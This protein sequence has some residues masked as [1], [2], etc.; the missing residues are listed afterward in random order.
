MT[1]SHRLQRL[2]QSRRC[3]NYDGLHSVLGALYACSLAT[4]WKVSTK[5]CILGPSFSVISLCSANFPLLTL[6]L[7]TRICHLPGHVM[8][9]T[10]KVVFGDSHGTSYLF[11][12]VLYQ[13]LGSLLVLRLNPRVRSITGFNQT[14]CADEHHSRT[15]NLQSTSD[16][17]YNGKE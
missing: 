7:L 1:W 9:L 12:S 14:N 5:N 8:N 16:I 11:L 6:Q 15:P 2:G 3:H 4:F 17:Q 10:D 13:H